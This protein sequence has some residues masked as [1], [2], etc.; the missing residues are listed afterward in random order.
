MDALDAIDA[1]ARKGYILMVP[2]DGSK[3]FTSHSG[4]ASIGK[5]GSLVSYDGSAIQDGIKK[6]DEIA[7]IAR[8]SLYY[9]DIL[10]EIYSAKGRNAFVNARDF[11]DRLD[12]ADVLLKKKH[13]G[14]GSEISSFID[15]SDFDETEFVV[16]VSEVTVGIW[17]NKMEI[18]HGVKVGI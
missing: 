13:I 7:F 16:M 15:K 1:M 5:S 9:A 14:K 3:V 10:D 12:E 8:A 17:R 4:G 18:A 2:F 6:D 11:N